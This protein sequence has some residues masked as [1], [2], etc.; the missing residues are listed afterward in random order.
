MNLFSRAGDGSFFTHKFR[1]KVVGALSLGF[2][3][4]GLE[5]TLDVI[6][7]MVSAYLMIPVAEG[8]AMSS[9]RAFGQ[10]PKYMEHGVLDDTWGIRQA[11][12]V[13]IRVVEVA[14]MVRHATEDGVGLR[15]EQRLLGT[16]GKLGDTEDKACVEGVGR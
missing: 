4:F 13:G 9:T 5:R 16:V 2:L 7:T 6:R 8:S 14:R 11:R 1:N 15:E 12:V 3:G 10:R